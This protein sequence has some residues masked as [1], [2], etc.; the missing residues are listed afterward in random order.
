MP[1][2]PLENFS[3]ASAMGSETGTAMYYEKKKEKA[4]IKLK[5]KIA[6]LKAQKD[7]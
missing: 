7:K 1:E 3:T 6:K 5:M 2:L 4:E